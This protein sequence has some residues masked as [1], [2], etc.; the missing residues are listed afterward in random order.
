MQILKY[1]F[2]I[3]LIA[4]VSRTHCQII[5]EKTYGNV[6]E[7]RGEG[8]VQLPDSSYMVTGSTSS[9]GDLSTDLLILKLD[10]LGEVI[11]TKTR[12]GSNVDSGMEIIATSDNHLAIIGYTNSFGNG[13][14]DV[15]FLKMDF[16]GSVVQSRTYGGADWDLGY[17]IAE[18]TDGGFVLTGETYSSSAGSNDAFVLKI[19]ALGDTVWSKTYGGIGNEIGWSIK[20]AANGDL[21]LAGETSTSSAGGQDAWL[22][23]MD[24]N[25]TV[26]WE[27]TFGGTDNDLGA[28]LIELDNGNLMFVWNTIVP[29]NDYWSTVQ[30]KIDPLTGNSMLDRWFTNPYNYFSHK[31]IAVQ[32]KPLTLT[33]GYNSPSSNLDDVMFYGLDTSGMFFDLVCFG[34]SF[35]GSGMDYGKDLIA[36][37]DGGFALVGEKK[38]GVGYSSVF[39]I[40]MMENCIGTGSVIND[41]IFVTQIE[42]IS[43]ENP[44]VYPNPSNGTMNLKSNGKWN[45]I[46]LFSLSGKRLEEYE[47][48]NEEVIIESQLTSGAYLFVLTGVDDI[49]TGKLV[50]IK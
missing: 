30:S 27:Q 22:I 41:S 13:G 29:G 26:I 37:S 33:V 9:F 44:L 19:D 17:S 36:T 10:S 2:I 12:G 38:I 5:F 4:V 7:E 24:S 16:N 6:Q 18:T 25:G 20:E 39:V 31:I 8:I 35:G 46:Q 50:I 48:H 40:K 28:D 45:T 14:Y 49:Q 34:I 21:L 11:W 43:N 3:S 42:T 15:Y 32:G 1:I 47:I 23:R